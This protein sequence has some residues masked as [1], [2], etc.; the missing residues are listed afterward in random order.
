MKERVRCK[1]CGYIMDKDALTDVCPA[2]GVKK[3]MFEAYE[4]KIGAVRRLILDKHLHPVVVHAPQALAFL[5]LIL[6]LV[7]PLFPAQVKSLSLSPTIGV[8]S[9]LL[10]LSVIAGFLSGLFDGKVRFRKVTTPLLVQKMVLGGL[11]LASSLAQLTLSSLS[12]FN[13]LGLWLGFLAASVVSV[14]C[15]A[16]LGTIGAGLTHAGMPGDKVFMGKKK[17]PAPVK[18]D[19]DGE[20]KAPV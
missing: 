2:C 6:A 11:F 7:Y 5:V 9:W 8:L 20:P 17:K 12:G 4:D 16:A 13:D 10:P 1:A 15:S 3:E 18:K 14:G 19:K